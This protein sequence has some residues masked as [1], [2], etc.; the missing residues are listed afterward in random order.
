MSHLCREKSRK[1]E[2]IQPLTAEFPFPD[3]NRYRIDFERASP[4]VQLCFIHFMKRQYH[5]TEAVY[6]KVAWVED[7]RSDAERGL[8]N[9]H[10]YAQNQEDIKK[11][12]FD[13]VR[14]TIALR[15][16]NAFQAFTIELCNI[17]IHFWVAFLHH[18]QDKEQSF[19]NDSFHIAKLDT[20]FVPPWLSSHLAQHAFMKDKCFL[21]RSVV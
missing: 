1:H 19:L 20:I 13:T 6:E 10:T 18:I 12:S 15:I 11:R 14:G 7:T 3:S 17:T 4:E 16:S 9:D 21:A 5:D 2:V 8:N